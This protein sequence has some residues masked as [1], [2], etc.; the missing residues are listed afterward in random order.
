MKTCL[1]GDIGVF[2]Y[3]WVCVGGGLFWDKET[4]IIQKQYKDDKLSA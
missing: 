4:F 1:G 2:L 3:F